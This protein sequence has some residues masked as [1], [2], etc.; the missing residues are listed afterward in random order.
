MAMLG[1]VE[2]VSLRPLGKLVSREPL[3]RRKKRHNTGASEAQRI[4]K[5]HKVGLDTNSKY[6]IIFM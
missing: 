3:Q 6:M 4:I 5:A 1:D 2:E